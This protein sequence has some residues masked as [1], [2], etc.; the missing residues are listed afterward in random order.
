MPRSWFFYLFSNKR[1]QGSLEKW[2]TVGLGWELYKT[3]SLERYIEG[4]GSPEERAP[5]G[6][7]GGI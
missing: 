1:N 2:L 3:I 7:A 4:H 5:A 6:K